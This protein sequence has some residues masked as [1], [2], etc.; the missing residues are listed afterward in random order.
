M[1]TMVMRALRSRSTLAAAM[2]VTTALLA[3]ACGG[4]EQET[5]FE[6]KRVIAFG[7]ETSLIVDLR[8]DGNGSK[9]SVNQTVSSTDRTI[10][11]RSSPIWIQVV[12]NNY[13]LLFP[14]CN[15]GPTPQANP[16]SRVRA[17]FGAR[18][19]DLT[20]QIATQ[21]AESSFRSDD[22]ATVL[23]GTNDILAAYQQYPGVGEGQLLADV[24]AAASEV[25]R[26]VNRLADLDVRVLISTLPDLRY[27]PYA[28]AENAAHSDTNR[29][30]LIGR[31]VTRFNTTLRSTIR[32]DGT[33]IGIVLTDEF[34][35]TAARVNGANGIANSTTPV[36]DLA[37]SQLVPP[38]IL[39]CT[40]LTLIAN[41]SP[42]S[43]LWADDRHLAA[44]AQGTMGNL[45]SQ[46][47]RNNPF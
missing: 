18:A 5:R 34:V 47:A 32:N 15:P 45:A 7:D 11:C 33:R 14:Q 38:S 44:G 42:T 39:D 19:A 26:Q 24:D 27:S 25:S 9:Y 31:L 30:E 28:I 46:R 13:G 20:Q 10:A 23:V 41:G 12:A 1:T 37:K 43:F 16:Q 17:T 36:C 4:G 21:T 29:A 8:A 40:Q 3:V 6:A 2:T 22:L 35:Q